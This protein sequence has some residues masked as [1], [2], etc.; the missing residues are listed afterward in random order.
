QTL[1]ARDNITFNALTTTGV[2]GDAG[3]INVDADTGFIL[4]QTVVSGGLPTL[5]SVS[6]SGSARLIAAGSNTGR[7]LTAASGNA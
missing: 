3:S 1:H 6:A 4:A 7:S 2:S 5:G